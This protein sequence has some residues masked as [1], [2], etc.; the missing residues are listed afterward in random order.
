[1]RWNQ[2]MRYLE[3]KHGFIV[4]QYYIGESGVVVLSVRTGLETVGEDWTNPVMNCRQ[5]S[6]RRFSRIL[7]L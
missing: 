3:I 4:E 1:M 7:F 5:L 6:E 2:E